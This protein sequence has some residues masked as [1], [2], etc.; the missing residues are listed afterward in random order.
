MTENSVKTE[1]TV[2]TTRM[3]IL[4]L[5]GTGF[6]GRHAAASLRSRGHSVLIGTRSPRRALAKL[7]P[8]LRDCDLRETH[9]ESLTTRYVWEPLLRDV[10]VVLNSV[11][12][13]R[14]RASETYDR[15]HVMAPGALAQAC[16]RLGVRL[17]HVSML[18]LRQESRSRLL[19]SRLAG[20]R[21]IAAAGGD[22]SIVRPP[23]LA[24]AGGLGADW[25]ARLA[26]WPVHAVPADATGRFPALQA[27]DLGDALA[28]LCEI[29]G[30][31]LPREIE[32][33]GAAQRTLSGHLDALR[34]LSHEGPALTLPAPRLALRLACGICDLL[35]ATPLTS[36]LLD[37]LRRDCLPKENLLQAL[38]R[39]APA[40]VGREPPRPKP[41]YAFAAMGTGHET[42]VPPSPQ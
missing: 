24:G 28:A 20:E 25:L 35:Y 2:T 34:A 12:I 15:V 41:S 7:P 19:R 16:A 11:G 22:Y 38:I 3:R 27:Q 18:G 40:P 17:I 30:T 4:V 6:V 36:G 13:L 37:L 10:D 1:I 42:P 8:V 39:R 29:P 23:L 26:R 5:G 21:A 9:L 31:S 33:G 14:E 32:L